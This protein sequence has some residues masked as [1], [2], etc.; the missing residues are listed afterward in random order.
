MGKNKPNFPAWKLDNK[1]H[2]KS[3]HIYLTDVKK[4]LTKAVVEKHTELGFDIKIKE[5]K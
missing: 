1:P 4:G 5:Q 3:I 2:G